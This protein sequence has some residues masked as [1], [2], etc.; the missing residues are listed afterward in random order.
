[1][2]IGCDDNRQQPL[3]CCGPEYVRVSP[4]PFRFRLVLSI[5]YSKPR[6]LIHSDCCLGKSADDS[7]CV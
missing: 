4:F 7:V 2:N 6:E 1:M 3:A 5:F